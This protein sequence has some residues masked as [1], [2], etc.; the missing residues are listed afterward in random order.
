[1]TKLI[2]ITNELRDQV[3]S[4]RRTRD[5]LLAANNRYLE[6]ARV[7]ERDRDAWRSRWE[8]ATG[9]TQEQYP[10]HTDTARPSA[11]PPPP[12][13]SELVEKI[14]AY[15]E[16]IMVEAEVDYPAGY[17]A[18]ARV[19]YDSDE[20]QEFITT[21]LTTRNS[22][23]EREVKRLREALT[24]FASEADELAV[25]VADDCVYALPRHPDLGLSDFDVGDL[26]AASR[27][28]S[29]SPQGGEHE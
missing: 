3:T 9:Q 21:T 29:T 5:D 23:L 13:V 18:G 15:I 10:L 12:P 7:A 1:M 26:R 6:R 17:D 4:L 8:K 28:L 27:A 24:P 16:D 22:E 11:A 20:I 25:G 19:S 14:M 2:P